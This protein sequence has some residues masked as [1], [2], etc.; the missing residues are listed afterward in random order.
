LSIN[1]VYLAVQANKL[2]ERQRKISRAGANV[3][4][5][6]SRMKVERAEH[7]RRRKPFRARGIVKPVRL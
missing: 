7:F 3:G 4:Y 5:R 1:C 6:L 2:R